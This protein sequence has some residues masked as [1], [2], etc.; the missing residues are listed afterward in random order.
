[1][2]A[3]NTCL[4]YFALPQLSNYDSSSDPQ[5]I[6]DTCASLL[7]T[8]AQISL[9]HMTN[10]QYTFSQ[11]TLEQAR[12]ILNLHLARYN[13]PLLVPSLSLDDMENLKFTYAYT[14]ITT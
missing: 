2:E 6:G 14:S 1:M 11:L 4:S 12:Q 10:Y 13:S 7:Q 3:V 5:S 8:L 9:L